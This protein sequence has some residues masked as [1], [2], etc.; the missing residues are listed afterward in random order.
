MLTIDP[1]KVCHIITMAR[2]FDADMPL[3]DEDEDQ[4]SDLAEGPADE[5]GGE[6]EE[7][8]AESQDSVYDELKEF[9]QEL[10]EDEQIEL[11][12]LTWIGRGSYG[13]EE[14]ADALDEATRAHNER[15]ADYLLG[16][17]VLADY[18]EEG[19]AGFGH[20]CD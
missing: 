9:I 1:D 12:A 7:V 18:L 15:T 13:V 19:L 8:E 16:I 11:V 20:R 5:I 4:G 6:E 3:V 10:N 14:W 2:V 17:P